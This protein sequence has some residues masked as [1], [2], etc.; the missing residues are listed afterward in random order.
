MPLLMLT[1]LYSRRKDIVARRS[2]AGGK[3]LSGLS[4]LFRMYNVNKVRERS[5]D[6]QPTNFTSNQP[7]NQLISSP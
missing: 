4:F 7:T 1:L 3:S 2:R 5:R 6:R